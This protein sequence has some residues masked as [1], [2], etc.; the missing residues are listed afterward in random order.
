MPTLS[1]S[2]PSHHRLQWNPSRERRDTL[3]LSGHLKIGLYL[4]VYTGLLSL[5]IELAYCFFLYPPAAMRSM[6][7]D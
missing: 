3:I 6:I 5:T 7:D 4:F 1:H 2:P